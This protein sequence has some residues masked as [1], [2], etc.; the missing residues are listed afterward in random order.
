MIVVMSQH[1]TRL[2]LLAHELDHAY[3]MVRERVEGLTEDEFWWAPVPEPWTVRQR[4]DGR[5]A[6]DYEEPDPV[7]APFTTVGWRLVHIAECKI[8]YHEYAFG[9]GRLMWPDIDS[10]HTAQDAIAQ[11][12]H[13]H[14]LLA[15]D[16]ASLD[17]QELERDR[18]TNWG[19]QW[20]TWMIFWT[21]IH[22]DIHHGAEIGVLRD[23]YRHASN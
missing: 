19:E 13:G 9:P 11:L 2:Q 21:M 14:T 5:W 4:P 16:L 12:D 3:R 18:A 17:D 15:A 1:G 7:P 20:P 10:A 8:M 22:H 6:A 23:L